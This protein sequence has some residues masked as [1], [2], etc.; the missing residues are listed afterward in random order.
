[1]IGIA[2]ITPLLFAY[3]FTLQA[4]KEMNAEKNKRLEELREKENKLEV[5]RV[6]Y[7]KLTSEDEVVKKAKDKFDLIRIDHL[8]HIAVNKNRIQNI[9]KFIAKKYD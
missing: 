3:L 7:Q 1:M 8:D 2:T 4:I 5:K 9:K 6:T